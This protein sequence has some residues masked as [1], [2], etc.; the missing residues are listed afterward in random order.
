M[1]FVVS[2]WC[3]V[4]NF[5]MALIRRSEEEAGK[6]SEEGA[7]RCCVDLWDHD[8]VEKCPHWDK[9]PLPQ[10]ACS[11]AN[12][13]AKYW[14]NKGKS[15]Q[16]LFILPGR[17]EIEAVRIALMLWGFQ[18]RWE[19]YMLVDETPPAKKKDVR[20]RFKNQDFAPD[21]N[22]VF[23]LST[24][25]YAEDGRTFCINGIVDSGLM[26]NVDSVMSCCIVA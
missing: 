8:V 20:L 1:H 2:Y 16:I 17:S 19:L 6:N 26:V 13:M 11:A 14:W 10:K 24:V 18:F 9:L 23:V 3:Y 22:A 4:M 15:A 12:E 7:V 21:A 5:E 25:R